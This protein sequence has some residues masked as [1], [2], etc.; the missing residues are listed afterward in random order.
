MVLQG[1]QIDLSAK[2]TEKTSGG[3]KRDAV[4]A[5]TP[6]WTINARFDRAIL[7][8][9]ES[10]RNILMTSSGGGQM[11]RLLDVVGAM[12]AGA[13]FSIKIEPLAGKRHLLVQTRDAG[14]FLRG[15][16]AIQRCDRVI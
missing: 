6:K 13:G 7:A 15:I 3:D 2:L 10:A 11:I 1:D 16:D 14:D 4:E 12:E 9:G 5:T 8:N